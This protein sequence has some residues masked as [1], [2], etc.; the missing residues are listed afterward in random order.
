[1]ERHKRDERKQ[2]SQEM[3]L[4]HQLNHM[5]NMQI[6]HG[7]FYRGQYFENGQ[8]PVTRK[9]VFTSEAIPPLQ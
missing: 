8:P 9:N 1:M 5:A 4:E 7:V 3:K 2:Q 6:L